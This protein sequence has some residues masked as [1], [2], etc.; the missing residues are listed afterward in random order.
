MRSGLLLTLLLIAPSASAV[1]ISEV[2]WMGSQTSANHEWIELYNPSEAVTVDGWTLSDG[3]N[4]NI[5]LSGSVPGNSYVVLERN[6]SDGNS[7]VGTPFLNYAGALVNT[8][9]TLTLRRA[10]GSVVD[11]VVGGENWQN[12][13]GDNVTKETAQYTNGGWITAAATPGKANAISGSLPPPPTSTTISGSSIAPAVLTGAPGTEASKRH[14]YAHLPWEL[15]LAILAPA[16]AQVNQPVKLRAEASGL[17]PTHLDSLVYS[18]NLGDL[19][20]KGTDMATHTYTYPGTYIV[21]LYAT[22]AKRE[23]T[24]THQITV[25][26]VQFSLA[27]LANGDVQVYNDT[28]YEV[29]ISG[30]TLK[31]GT[32]TVVFPPRSFM[33]A[34]ST[35]T[36]P[37]SRIGPSLPVV[38][39]DQAGNWVAGTAGIGA[40]S[41][42]F[43]IT[44]PAVI[45]S[46]QNTISSR[47]VTSQSR[48]TN[49]D[50]VSAFGFTPSDSVNV[51][52]TD[53]LPTTSRQF[54][55]A[56]PTS[57]NSAT[58]TESSLSSTNNAW[59]YTIFALLL[60]VAVGV[61]LLFPSR[62][63]H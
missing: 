22:F 26:P 58:A 7:V 12:I 39:Y 14:T 13:G 63:K 33:S 8:G 15:E 56:L 25:L 52:I 29:D 27:R 5:S 51:T 38:L 9:A 28:T 34:R 30:F 44:S 16:T 61:I 1:S 46:G 55:S 60:A 40:S 24:A 2:A 53:T 11:Q 62:S 4:L 19:T 43:P 32:Q 20:T 50:P 45:L 47:S 6:R 17:G 57:T 37:V 31:S 42:A 18:W 49:S 23:A 41:T 35:L 54:T 36:V 48:P 59:P 10:D 21:T 3:M